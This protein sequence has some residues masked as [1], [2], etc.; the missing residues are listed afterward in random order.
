M[1]LDEIEADD[2][3]FRQREYEERLF[4]VRC[5]ECGHRERASEKN[6]REDGW[7]LSKAGEICSQCV[8]A[9]DAAPL[10]ACGSDAT[11]ADGYCDACRTVF[12]PHKSKV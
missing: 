7:S 1:H 8:V 11:A 3:A 2:A 5:A 9:A 10:C 6:L 12:A 4:D